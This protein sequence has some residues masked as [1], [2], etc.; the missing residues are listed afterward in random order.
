MLEHLE[1]RQLMSVA[2]TRLE[3]VNA[4]TGKDILALKTGITLNLATLPTK[5]LNVRADVGTGTLSVKFGLDTNASYRTE[6]SLP[7]ALAGD[8]GKGHYYAWTPSLGKHTLTATPYSAKFA[9]GT[10]GTKVS[11]AFTVTN[12]APPTPTPTPV[13]PPM[14]STWSMNFDEEFTGPLSDSV[15][16]QTLWGDN[17]APGD[18]ET[19]DPSATSV[20][21][22]VL[23]ITA[24]QE[25]LVGRDYVS[26]VVNTGGTPGETAP[27]FSFK[28]GYIE[29]RMKAAAG[30]GLW[31][32]IWM[33]PTPDADGT[34]H[35]GGGE[36]DIAEIIGR[37]LGTVTMFTHKPTV[38]HG[39]DYDT[40]I[41]LTQSFHTYGLDWEPDHLTWFID[42]KAM[43]TVTDVAS[44]PQ[45]AEYLIMNLSVGTATSWPQAP[46][47][48]TVFPASMQVDWIHVWQK[49]S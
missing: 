39:K 14:D 48:S 42:N 25:E 34:F 35:D 29:A 4:D 30:W 37:S 5:H 40:K 47:S 44:I 8:D 36:L 28:Y 3:L 31:N 7:L 23:S 1:S 33:L 18:A 24:R 10:A 6:S 46:N 20:D 49:N 9:A 38:S 21:S 22:G 16:T 13:G 2:V 32:A 27:G 41:N 12:V 43:F 19:Y 11:I 45:V 15:W 26:G 17:Q